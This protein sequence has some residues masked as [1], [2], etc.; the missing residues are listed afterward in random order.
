MRDRRYRWSPGASS[1]TSCMTTGREPAEDRGVSP[2]RQD[3]HEHDSSSEHIVLEHVVRP[4]VTSAATSDSARQAFEPRHTPGAN[5]LIW[6]PQLER[7]HFLQRQAEFE[8]RYGDRYVA[9]WRGEVVAVAETALEAAKTARERIGRQVSLFI[10][11]PT[12]PL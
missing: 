9:M 6:T 3:E 11:N 1:T 2:R 8:A 10:H 5:D 4:S 12:Q 7:D